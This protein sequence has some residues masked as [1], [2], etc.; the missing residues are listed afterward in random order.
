LNDSSYQEMISLTTQ[1][2]STGA[3]L[4]EVAGVNAMTDVTGFGLLGHLKEIV[5]G[6]NVGAE[7]KL[8]E[9]PFVDSAQRLARDGVVTG[10]SSRNWSSCSE[11]VQYFDSMDGFELDLLT[12][13]QTS[14]GLLVT[15]STSIEETVLEM[16]REDGFTRACR[17][18]SIGGMLNKIRIIP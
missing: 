8:S 2:N 11:Y 16:F 14:G 18:G 6:S 9:V 4:G 5:L 15:C 17:I 13:P 3:R 1:I 10:A 12:D 7:I